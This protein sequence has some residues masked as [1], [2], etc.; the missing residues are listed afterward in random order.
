MQR[1]VSAL[2]LLAGLNVGAFGQYSPPTCRS[3]NAAMS[4]SFWTNGDTLEHV[5]GGHSW[6]DVPTGTC[7]YSGPSPNPYKPTPCNVDSEASSR[8]GNQSESGKLD[9]LIDH[10]VVSFDQV[11]GGATTNLGGSATAGTEGAFSVRSCTF[12]CNIIITFAATSPVGSYS[13]NSGAQLLWSDKHS[14]ENTC[15]GVTLPRIC[16]PQ[17]K[18]PHTLSTAGS[19]EW[20]YSACAWDWVPIFNASPILVD[21][22]R[23]GFAL[24]DP[25]KGRYVTFDL[26]GNGKPLRLSWPLP[27]SGNAWLVYDRDGDGIIKDGTELFG[28]NT[29]HSNYTNPNLPSQDWNGFIALGWYDLQEQ[30]GTGD[31]IID[32]HDRIWDKLRLWI[33]THCFR[34]PDAP[35][36]SKSQEL[37]TLESFGITSISLVYEYDPQNYDRAGNRFKFWAYLNPELASSPVDAHGH[38]I[39]DPSHESAAQR[40]QDAR[41][42]YGVVLASVP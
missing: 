33:D 6:I 34:S 30:G 27:T 36:H 8:D 38:H 10:H 25:T 14:Y 24:S 17:G 35:C 7:T 3:Y 18:H 19:Y 32:K 12:D 5:T 21:T 37:H 42:A 9:T 23:T 1:L 41:K 40:S 29:P 11:S 15:R 26:V 13:V 28:N 16:V 4:P 39:Q 20:N 22:A 31:Q 2:I